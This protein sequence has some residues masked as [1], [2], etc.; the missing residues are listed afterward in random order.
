MNSRR[1]PENRW[2]GPPKF[3]FSTGIG[4]ISYPSRLE[5][6]PYSLIGT[7]LLPIMPG[8]TGELGTMNPTV[9]CTVVNDTDEE[10]GEMQTA[11]VSLRRSAGTATDEEPNKQHNF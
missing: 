4:K 1:F 10:G 5:N 3:C 6:M 9:S 11:R 7:K 2:S 8:S